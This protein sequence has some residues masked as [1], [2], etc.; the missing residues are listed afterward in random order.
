MAEEND[1]VIDNI[2]SVHTFTEV[3]LIYN[4][5]EIN[6]HTIEISGQKFVGL[7]QD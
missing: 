3:T 5:F 2:Q 1:I 6:T 7:L 4:E